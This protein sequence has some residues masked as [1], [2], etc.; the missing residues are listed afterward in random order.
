MKSLITRPLCCVSVVSLESRDAHLSALVQEAQRRASE[1]STL[2]MRESLSL[3]I[4]DK[5][6]QLKAWEWRCK[7][8][9]RMRTGF[10]HARKSNPSLLLMPNL[11]GEKGHSY[12]ML[13]YNT[14]W[15][16][17]I[18]YQSC[19]IYQHLCGKVIC[20]HISPT[21]SLYWSGK[22]LQTSHY[23]HLAHRY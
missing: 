6:K 8:Y 3:E 4:S 23:D 16:G 21:C 10:E 1:L 13:Q 19:L 22:T 17:L 18:Y 20:S 7:L 9:K 11:S 12:A 2:V 14:H 5:E 15:T